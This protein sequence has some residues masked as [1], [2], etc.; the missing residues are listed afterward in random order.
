MFLGDVN[1]CID[2]SNVRI[3]LAYV[4]GKSF[5]NGLM[6]LETA[7]EILIEN[8][9]PISRLFA[10]IACILCIGQIGNK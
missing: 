8:F 3:L 9:L 10:N 6:K 4:V 1:I 5:P 2:I 7:S